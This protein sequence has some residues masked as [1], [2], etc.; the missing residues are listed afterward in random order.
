MRSFRA[1]RCPPDAALYVATTVGAIDRL[2]R[3][4]LAGDAVSSERLSAIPG[5]LAGAASAWTPERAQVVSAACASSTAAL[6][7]AAVRDPPRRDRLR[8]RGGRRSRVGIRAV[9]FSALMAIDPE[10]ARPFDAARKG[11][12]LGEARVR[13][14]DEPRTRGAGRASVPGRAGRLGD[15]LR[16]EPF[17]RAVARRRAA[18]GGRAAGLGDGRLRAGADDGPLRARHRDDVQRPDGNAG[19]PARSSASRRFRRFPRRA[20]WAMGWARPGVAEMLLSLEFLRRGRVPPTIGLEPRASDEAEGWVA[21][22]AQAI[23]P[24]GMVSTNSGFGGTNAALA[25]SLAPRSPGGGRRR[26]EI[27]GDPRVGGNPRGRGGWRRGGGGCEPPKNFGRFSAEAR[28]AY[29]AVARALLAAGPDPARRTGVVACGEA[30]ATRPTAR[31]FRTMRD[32]AGRWGAASVR[33]DAAD[34]GRGGMRDRLPADGPAGLRGGSGRIRRGRGA[35]A[36]GM[37]GRWGGGSIGACPPRRRRPG[38]RPGGGTIGTEGKP[39]KLKLIYPRWPK[40]Q[41]QTEFHLPPHGPS[42]SRRR[43]RRTSP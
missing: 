16:R 38:V 25:V 7:L 35:A 15:D 43:C 11:V 19:V 29:R 13:A 8:A 9:G 27:T 10:G 17:D 40:L 18:G 1:C 12:T 24:A 37:A 23:D 32:R 33:A 39:M 36:R 3:S 26:L 41:H 30:A 2:E 5:R 14:A 22:R 6:A 21:N 20:G 4:V 28:L 42:A 34:L 31:I